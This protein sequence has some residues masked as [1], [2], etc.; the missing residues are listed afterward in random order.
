MNYNI[1]AENLTELQKRIA[2]INA[3]AAKLNCAPVV[4]TVGATKD[5]PHPDEKLAAQGRMVRKVDVEL[6]GETPKYAGWS[7]LATICHTSDGNVVRA[8]PGY[9][10]PGSYRDGSPCC[11]HCKQNRQRRDTY[12]V[13]NEQGDTKQVGSSCMKDFLG[14]GDPHAMMNYAEL[15]MSAFDLCHFYG[16]GGGRMGETYRVDLLVFLSHVAAEVRKAHRFVT[17]KAA[18]ETGGSSTAD[19]AWNTVHSAHEFTVTDEDKALAEQ[20]RE[21]VIT[22]YSPVIAD[23]ASDFDLKRS[24]LDQF[25]PSTGAVKTMSDFEHNLL[26]VARAEAIEARLSGIAA[27]IMEAFRREQ[28]RI[29][30][31]KP[32]TQLDKGGLTRIFEMFEKASATLKRPAIRLADEAGHHIALSLAGKQSTNAGFIYVKGGDQYFGKIS[33]QGRFF[34]VAACPSTVEAQLLALAANPEDVAAKYGKMT[35]C[36]CFCGRSLTDDRSTDVGYGP[37]CADKYGLTWGKHAVEAEAPVAAEPV[38]V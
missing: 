2:R 5:I 1:Y 9:E 12:I 23:D 11:D 18:R 35:G 38:A 3:R 32:T 4:L 31:S 37:V 36:C 20:A 28:A 30:A 22:T 34:P 10:V 17:R 15:V 26:T 8:I 19:I 25:R 21:W 6:V 27:Y 16:N 7:F 33:P 29:T 14:E 24:V 13:R